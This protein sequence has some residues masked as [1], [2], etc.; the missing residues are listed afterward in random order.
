M[1]RAIIVDDEKHALNA[2]KDLLAD[3]EDIELIGEFTSSHQALEHSKSLQY[4]IAFL[5]IEM[6]EL[7]GLELGQKL[8]E[9]DPS[10]D[11][12]FVTAFDVYA[13]EAFEIHALDY[14]LKPVSPRRM[15][16][17]VERLKAKQVEA[18][19][20]EA[21]DADVSSR[22]R[23]FGRFEVLC[24][25][26]Q[27]GHVPWRTA[28]VR[29]L[30]AYL[31]HHRGEAVHKSRIIED[32]WPHMQPEKATVYMHTCIYQIRKTLKKYGLDQNIYIR[33]MKEGY[34]LQLQAI[35]TDVDEYR[36]ALERTEGSPEQ[37]IET[38]KRAAHLYGAGYFEHEDYPWSV[39]VRGGLEEEYHRLLLRMAEQHLRLGQDNEAIQTLRQLVQLNPWNEDV[40]ETLFKLY[41][42]QGDRAS[43]AQMYQQM[44]ELYHSELG[45][46]P[47]ASAVNLYHSLMDQLNTSPRRTGE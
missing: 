22:L 4:D 40:Y 16:K 21:T 23:C 27:E 30:L 33:F 13:V 24:D 5:D 26:A 44:Q 1:I 9:V 46:A 35:G 2:L 10:R 11:V 6:P 15:R 36:L 8:L 41:A 19:A 45:I 37:T 39:E 3:Y 12:V 47:R 28:K 7:Q 25:S 32:L 31:I 43:L 34:H 17:T 14:L 20:D 29:E 18:E 42:D 38:L